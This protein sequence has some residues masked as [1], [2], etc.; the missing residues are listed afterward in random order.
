MISLSFSRPTKEIKLRDVM[1]NIQS[2]LVIAD[3]LRTSFS[4]RVSE[5]P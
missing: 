3:M 4:V 1:V 5:S 2:T